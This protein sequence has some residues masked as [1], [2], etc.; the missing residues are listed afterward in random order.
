MSLLLGLQFRE[1]L[2]PIVA[3][4]F[5]QVIAAI[6]TAFNSQATGLL[7]WSAV[8]FAAQNFSGWDL[9]TW[10]VEPGDYVTY[11]YARVGR[12]AYVSF[13]M[14]NTTVGGT[15]S[16]PLRL[17][18]PDGMVADK[19]MS[20]AYHYIDNGT[21]GVGL[22]GIG[23]G[24]NEIHLYKNDFTVNWAASTN[25]TDVRGQLAFEVRV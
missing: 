17:T 11:S 3:E 19:E 20:T 5:D 4:E 6:Q 1:Q 24:N 9:M 22:C 16:T 12:F 8:P 13:R 18:L 25:L 2:D 21:H 23:A 7:A 15:P 10:T 14:S